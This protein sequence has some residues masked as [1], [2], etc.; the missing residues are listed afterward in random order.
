MNDGF[1]QHFSE[2]KK[3]NCGSYS[4]IFCRLYGQL[5]IIWRNRTWCCTWSCI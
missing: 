5:T 4:F 2:L 1:G 3:K